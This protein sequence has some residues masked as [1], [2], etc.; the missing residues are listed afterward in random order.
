MR[1]SIRVGAEGPDG[2]FSAEAA[3]GVLVA[4]L[5]IGVLALGLIRALRP[6]AIFFY[7]EAP[8]FASLTAFRRA[9]SLAALYPAGRWSVPPLVLT[10]YGP[11]FFLLDAAVMSLPGVAPS[12]VVPR[13]V[14]LAALAG[15]LAVG[16]S[17]GR[18]RGV[19]WPT[20]LLV[21]GAPL[22][23]VP[24]IQRLSGSAQVDVLALLCTLAGVRCV[25]RF[26][27]AEPTG[28][29]DAPPGT[30]T[31]QVRESVVARRYLL[32]G[33]AFFVVAYFT[34]QSYVAAPLAL[35]VDEFR[36]RRWRR[37]GLVAVA[38]VGPVAGG[39][40]LLQ[41]VTG[42]GYWL[43][44]A[45][46]MSV[47]MAPAN[48]FAVWHDASFLLWAPLL[49]YVLVRVGEARP[50]GFVTLWAAAAWLLHGLA[51]LKTGSSINYFLEPVFGTVVAALAP[52]EMSGSPAG[53]GA[54][55]DRRLAAVALV[56]LGVAAVPATLG[57]GRALSSTWRARG[58]AFGIRGAEPGSP[59]VF[60][61]AF[62]AV[63]EAGALPFLNDPYA[64]GTLAHAGLW[65]ASV[66]RRALA[67]GSIP[68]VATEFDLR[69]GP[70]RTGGSSIAGAGFTY[71][72]YLDDVWRP[73]VAHYRMDMAPGFFVWLPKGGDGAPGRGGSAAVGDRSPRSERERH[74]ATGRAE[75]RA[76]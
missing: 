20:R 65:D 41:A 49:L 24:G 74:V 27:E 59:L 1:G 18:S 73:T 19:P 4:A 71:F 31:G 2:A 8:V 39:T 25:L 23:F 56:V 48:L 30:A 58:L 75:S 42:G 45:S 70:S 38:F 51:M 32:A 10:P 35:V 62:P 60:S 50:L 3:A 63:I 21:L 28:R 52:V 36:L 76:H 68:F 22:L 34:K 14:A 64:F 7:T 5:G 11:L 29:S 9:G 69:L 37:A 66:V 67:T 55:A 33:V 12:L 53:A 6:H 61:E 17:I 43:N 40:L 72:W 16:W 47:A 26:R 13:M 54:R 15:C 57:L 44:T 46:A